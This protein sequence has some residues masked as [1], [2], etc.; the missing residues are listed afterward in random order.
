MSRPNIDKV[1][2]TTKYRSFIIDVMG[3]EGKE[4]CYPS[5]KRLDGSLINECDA[6][7]LCQTIE[8]AVNDG[9]NIIDQFLDYIH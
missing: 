6:V 8:E 9:K 7:E 2:Y 1:T 5:C 3:T 4:Y